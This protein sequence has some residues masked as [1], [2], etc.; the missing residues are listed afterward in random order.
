MT[1]TVRYV[2]AVDTAKLIRKTLRAGWPGVRFSVRT[3]TYAGGASIDVRWTDGPTEADVRR[4]TELYAG[5]TFDGM[6]DTKSF[7]DTVLVGPDGPEEVHFGAHH[8]FAT[9]DLSDE[10]VGAAAAMIR[11]QDVR[12][13]DRNGGQCRRCGDWQPAEFVWWAVRGRYGRELV[14]SPECGAHVELRHGHVRPSTSR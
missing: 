13:I 3:N 6:T 7:H 9:R 10:L 12:G 1:A 11:A 5:S 2:S 4:T 14:C 8:V